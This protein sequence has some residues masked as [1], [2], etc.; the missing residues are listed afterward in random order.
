MVITNDM[1]TFKNV[2][3]LTNS[4]EHRSP[5]KAGS[6]STAHWIPAELAYPEPDESS[7][8]PHPLF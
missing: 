6:H 4:M 7:Q 3:Q 8:Y 5:C 2:I 1:C